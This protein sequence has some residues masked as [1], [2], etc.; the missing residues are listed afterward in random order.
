MRCTRSSP[1][2][3]GLLPT[4]RGADAV[5]RVCRGIDVT[6][7]ERRRQRPGLREEVVDIRYGVG[8][9]ELPIVV[10]ISRIPATRRRPLR[11]EAAL[12]M[13]FESARIPVIGVE[14]PLSCLRCAD[15]MTYVSRLHSG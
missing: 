4:E 10:G 6:L 9:I 12:G 7:T 13:I 2:D 14:P 5:Q 11:E 8:T 3:R 15:I 1:D